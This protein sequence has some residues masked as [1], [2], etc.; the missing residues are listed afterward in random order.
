MKWADQPQRQRLRKGRFS[1]RNTTEYPDT[2]AQSLNLSIVLPLLTL[3]YASYYI[4]WLLT[5]CWL[6]TS[7]FSRCRLKTNI[8]NKIRD[9][10]VKFSRRWNQRAYFCFFRQC[11]GWRVASRAKF[12]YNSFSL[13]QIIRNREKTLLL[14]YYSEITP[15]TITTFTNS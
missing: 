5:F 6:W 15:L 4:D 9:I 11:G 1:Q 8:K 10:K 13:P 2:C 7:W 14:V 12:S 3:P